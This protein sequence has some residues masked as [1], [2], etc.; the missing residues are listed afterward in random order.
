MQAITFDQFGKADV[1]KISEVPEP[2]LRPDDL[3]VR[4]RAAGVNRA[5]LTHR[6]GGY[7][8][9]GFGDS[10]IMGL[11]IAGEVIAVGANVQGF[12]IGDR[13]MGIVGGGAYAEI[14]R[15]DYRMA[16]PIPDGLDFI[17]A[18]AITEV[19]VTAHEA[20]I[21]LGKLQPGET[22][23]IHAG[24]GGVGG[25]A[26]QLAHATGATVIT[27]AQSEAHALVRRLGADHAIDYVDEDFAEAVARLTDNRGVDLVLDFIG[28]PY[29]ERNV[30][31]LAFGGRLVQIGI[32]GGIEDARIPLDRLLYRHLQIIGTVMKSRTQE[33]KHAMSRRFRERWLAHFVRD[34]L[35]PVIDSVYPLAE[36]GAAQQ[37]ME[38]G[39]NVGKIVL[40]M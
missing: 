39:L 3:L 16:M 30:N 24:A 15:I 12:Q 7:G 27:T 6:R 35:T 21:H 2:V 4:T 11:E 13:V 20:L 23:L 33:V 32:M 14:A 38:D 34:G 22:V 26:V 31:A 28:A 5:D 25:A 10:T 37:R 36:A 18:A 9:P 17:Q 19:F 1:L 8:W 29:F 40:T